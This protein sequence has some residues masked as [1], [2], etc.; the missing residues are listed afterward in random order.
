MN[1]TAVVQQ[2]KCYRSDGSDS[3]ALSLEIQKH[4]MFKFNI[5]LHTSF[6]QTKWATGKK[7]IS[8]NKVDIK[9]I[10]TAERQKNS[11]ENQAVN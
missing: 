3:T 8:G 7:K 10:P 9:T 11:K 4:W 2:D 6:L 5:L 1:T